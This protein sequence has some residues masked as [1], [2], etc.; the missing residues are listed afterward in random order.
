MIDNDIPTYRK[1]KSQKSK[2][3]KRSNHKHQ[4]NKVIIRS[5][6]GWQWAEECT[7]CGR[8]KYNL[9]LSTKEF[10]KPEYKDFP[11]ISQKSYYSFEEMLELYPE[12]KII[13]KYPWEME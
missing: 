2:S 12:V 1:K 6:I 8:L 4:Y 7:L 5:I 3:S 9:K 13:N 11:Y 10:Q